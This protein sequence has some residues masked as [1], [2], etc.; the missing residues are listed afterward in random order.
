MFDFLV[1]G[2]I[3][4]EWV[5]VE[6][7]NLIVIVYLLVEEKKKVQNEVCEKFVVEGLKVVRLKVLICDYMIFCCDGV[8]IE[9]CIYCLLNVDEKEKLLVYI[10]FYGGGFMIGILLLEDMICVGI[11]INVGVMV[12]N[13]NYRY[14]FE[15]GYF[16]FWDDLEDVFEWFYDNIDDI[17]GD[18]QLV[19]IGGIFVGVWFMVFLL[20]RKYFGQ[21]IMFI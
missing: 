13:V 18:V 2:G 11:V 12:F 5:V 15:V 6:K 19:V 4:E 16:M 9:G 20:L 3:Y 8:Q 14:I 10:Y 17:Y 7:V 1:Y 21:F